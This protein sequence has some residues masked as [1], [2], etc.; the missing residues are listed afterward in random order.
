MNKVNATVTRVLPF[1][2]EQVWS[3][4]E[5]F[6]NIH[7]APGIDKLE[8]IGEGVGMIRRLHIEGL[9]EPIDEQ[10]EAIDPAAM[11]FSYIIPKGL[12]FPLKDYRAISSL[13]SEDDSSTTV[14]WQ[15]DCKPDGLSIE[16]SE[17]MLEGTYH[18][19]IDWITEELQK[20]H[21]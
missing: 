15:S 7:W 16:D 5:D 14:T 2:C 21:G 1:P 3:L 8:I 20:R 13:A 19:L 9:E 10:L 12:P 17:A 11:T 4:L 6:G 18:Q